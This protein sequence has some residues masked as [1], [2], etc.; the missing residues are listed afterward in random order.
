MR[1][2]VSDVV[3][4][5]ASLFKRSFRCLDHG[6]NRLLVHFFAGH[7]DGIQIQIDI[8]TRDRATRTAAGHE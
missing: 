7:V 2:D 3:N 5:Q 8:F 4:G 6:G 1:N